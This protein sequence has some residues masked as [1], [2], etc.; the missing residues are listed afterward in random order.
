M[1]TKILVNR[2]KIAK[3]ENNQRGTELVLPPI[4]Q[5]Q[6]PSVSIITVTR[7]RK[8]IFPLAIDNWNRFRYPNDKLEWVILDDSSTDTLKYL[9]PT[10]DKNI[11]YRHIDY[12]KTRSLG[13]KRN[14][15]C[16]LASNDYLFIMDDDD[17]HYADEILSK[18]RLLLYYKKDCVLSSASTIYSIRRNSTFICEN[19]LSEGMMCFT[20]SFWKLYKYNSVNKSEGLSLISGNERK[21]ILLPV[22]FNGILVNHRRNETGTTREMN[23]PTTTST[24]NAYNTIFSDPFKVVIRKLRDKMYEKDKE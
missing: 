1:K 13:E 11:I 21:C 4:E 3:T 17:W 8:R 22:Q 24:I 10:Q 7:N 20:K 19:Y 16:E 9:L 6:L 23:L 5:H 12:D 14:M 2:M 18:I 15:A